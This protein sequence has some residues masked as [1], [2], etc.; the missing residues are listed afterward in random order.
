MQWN[1]CFNWNNKKLS[2][3]HQNHFKENEMITIKFHDLFTSGVDINRFSYYLLTV[4][5]FLFPAF[6]FDSENPK[7]HP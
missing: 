4:V 1:S 5:V 6:R 7:G 3:G 2:Q